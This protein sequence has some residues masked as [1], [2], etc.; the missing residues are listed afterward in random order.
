MKLE[1]K[2]NREQRG[3][4]WRCIS[5]VKYVNLNFHLL[6]ASRSRGSPAET[7][8]PFANIN[9]YVRVGNAWQGIVSEQLSRMKSTQYVLG[10]TY[11][12][13]DAWACLYAHGG[14][15]EVYNPSACPYLIHRIRSLD[16]IPIVSMAYS[17]RGGSPEDT[18]WLVS[19]WELRSRRHNEANSTNRKRVCVRRGWIDEERRIVR[20]NGI[21]LMT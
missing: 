17:R 3:G 21:R 8:C 19:H 9:R 12:A 10:C 13:R 14:C 6:V 20:A 5:R 18:N 4:A 15:V 1:K 11:N 16:G 7:T 2:G